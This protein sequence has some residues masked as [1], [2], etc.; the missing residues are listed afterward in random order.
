ME[1]KVPPP[2]RKFFQ[3]F[4][5]EHFLRV[6][7]ELEERN[8]EQK[9]VWKKHLDKEVLAARYQRRLRKEKVKFDLEHI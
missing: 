6:L 4:D 8:V 9:K 2:V 3:G 7:E 1:K 5:E